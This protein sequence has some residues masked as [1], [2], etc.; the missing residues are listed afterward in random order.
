M[1]VD[2]FALEQISALEAA[3]AEATSTAAPQSTVDMHTH[4]QRLELDLQRVMEDLHRA[5][6]L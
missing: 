6:A 4:A 2:C 5:E 3:L 1:I